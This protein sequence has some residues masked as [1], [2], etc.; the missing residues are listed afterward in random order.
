MNFPIVLKPV[1]GVGCEGV[2]RVDHHYGL[3]PALEKVRS[4]TGHGQLVMQSLAA[5]THVSV[6]VLAG[7][8]RCMPLSLNRQ[9]I[10][11][12][13]CFQYLGSQVPFSHR[14]GGHCMELA[15]SAVKLLPGLK[16][17]V[18]VDLILSKESAQLIEINPRL[19]TSY[20]GLRQVSQ[21]N[22]AQAIWEACIL[23][24]LPDSVPISG[25]A[26]IRKD[27]HNSWR[28][29]EWLA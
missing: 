4:I 23:D 22:V 25:E 10:R 13:A 9:L 5:G 7:Q 2:C 15:C 14:A 3:F 8:N 1:D 12:G 21:V 20:I 11:E 24:I 19:T 29:S 6:S 27:D 16:G 28:L 26:I 18:G 17:Y